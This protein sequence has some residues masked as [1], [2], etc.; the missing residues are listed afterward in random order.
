MRQVFT[1][2]TVGYVRICYDEFLGGDL[3]GRQSC[4][5]APTPTWHILANQYRGSV[6]MAGTNLIQGM[7][8]MWPASLQV[9]WYQVLKMEVQSS[10]SIRLPRRSSRARASSGNSGRR[11]PQRKQS[12]QLLRRELCKRAAMAYQDATASRQSLCIR[13][14]YSK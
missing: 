6:P 4:L 12:H 14:G 3:G 13:R 11:R 1:A 2:T 8:L 10:L 5:S 9:G 7:K